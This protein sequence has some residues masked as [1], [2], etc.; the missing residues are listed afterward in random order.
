MKHDQIKRFVRIV[1]RNWRYFIPGVLAAG[2][3]LVSLPASAW[4]VAPAFAL[5]AILICEPFITYYETGRRHGHH[6]PETE[7]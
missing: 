5:L 2:V 7:R 4:W 3:A 1:I 6:D